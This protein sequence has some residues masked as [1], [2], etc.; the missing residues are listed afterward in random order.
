MKLR[1]KIIIS[2]LLTTI[3][4]GSA[5]LILI[6]IQSIIFFIKN[7]LIIASIISASVVISTVL[8]IFLTI[9]NISSPIS[10]IKL[11]LQKM[12]LG[13]MI[14]NHKLSINR[15]DDI[16]IISKEL[17]TLRKIITNASQ[18]AESLKLG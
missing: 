2:I 11:F 18:Y 6:P 9:K 10:E 4:I 7:N 13:E 12:N 14:K 8:I 1:F 3:V 15:T 17:L 16:G 5:F